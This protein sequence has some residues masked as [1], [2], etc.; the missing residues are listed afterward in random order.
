PLDPSTTPTVSANGTSATP[1]PT[2][3]AVSDPN[4]CVTEAEA[5]KLAQIFQLLIQNYTN[6]FALDTLTEDFID[7]SSSVNSLM[8]KGAQYPKDTLSATFDSRAKFMAGQ[9]S[10]P[11]IPFEILNVFHGCRHVAARWKTTRSGAGQK[12]EAAMIP[13]VGNGILDLIPADDNSLGWRVR[14][15]YSEFNTAAWLVNLGV[16]KPAGKVDYINVANTT[17]TTVKRSE[18]DYDFEW[19]GSM[20]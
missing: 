14:T 7:Y 1:G 8:N 18:E 16:F 12:T 20:I 15:L 10:Q 3:T 4:K 9:G 2:S 6:Q 5:P 17:N 11:L 19:R 13:L